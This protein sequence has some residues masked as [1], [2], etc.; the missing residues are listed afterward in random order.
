MLGIEVVNKGEQ[1]DAIERAGSAEKDAVIKALKEAK[2]FKGISGE[3]TMT[4]DGT[5]AK[6]NFVLLEAK[7]SKWNLLQ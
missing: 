5:F 1:E 4:D 2:G 3:V 7:D 6:S